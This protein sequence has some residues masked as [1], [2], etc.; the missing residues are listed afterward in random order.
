MV[1]EVEETEVLIIG[2]G[3]VGLMLANLLG[4]YGR[5]AVVLEARDELIDYPRAVGLDD[6]SFRLIQA[7]GLADQIAPLTGPAHIM[8]LVN[9][10][11]NVILYND[12]QIHRFGWSRKNGFNQPML[13]AQLAAGLDR[14]PGVELRF[15]H[16]VE[17]VVEDADGVTAVAL[18][19]DGDEVVERRIRAEYLV[20]C[21]GGKSPTRKRMGVAFDG[22]SPETRWLV[23]DVAND[24]LGTPNVWLGADRRRPYVSIGLPQA[25]RRW[26]F[27][28]HDDETDDVVTSAAW[29]QEAL[30]DHVPDPSSLEFIRWRVYSHHGRVAESFRRG[31]Q[32]IAGD[33]AHLMPVWLGQ[34][35]NSGVR[36]A[37]NL[38]WKLATVL[39][40]RADDRLL[41][42]YT[43]ERKA[44]VTAMVRLSMLMGSVIKMENPVAVAARDLAGRLINR[45]PKA[46]DYFGEM[47][48]RPLPRYERGVL[49]DQSTLAP[50]HASPRLTSRLI[51]F[52]QAVDKTSPVGTQFPQPIVSTREGSML[53]DEATG[54][55]WSLLTWINDPCALLGATGL[56]DA[57]RLGVRLV[58]VAPE[59]QRSWAEHHLPAQVTVIGD[60]TGELKRW[61]DT[62]PI[63][64]VLLRPDRFIAGACLAQQAPQLLASAHLALNPPCAP[65]RASVR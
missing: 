55:W 43:E 45:V 21:E 8:R 47:R 59:V 6:E 61:F 52:L 53:L 30:R 44:H 20:G 23:V 54:R 49:V 18:V 15:G 37:M 33:A 29:V 2:A 10:R 56:A 57:E 22:L 42:T 16:T 50:G 41:D 27:K 24:P 51:P 5:R 39:Q 28:L 31:R 63:G 32:L 14:F 40:G 19:R 34:G 65:A 38:G 60:E 46:R 64:A 4:V 36:D 25:I 12:P 13:D 3:P 62:K 11:G 35:W 26:E 58:V 7:V 48:F 17:D 9:A 1:P